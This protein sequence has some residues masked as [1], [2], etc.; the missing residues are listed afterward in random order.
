MRVPSTERL[1]SPGFAIWHMPLVCRTWTLSTVCPVPLQGSILPPSG[2]GSNPTW[3]LKLEPALREPQHLRPIQR[4]R[5]SNRSE[6]PPLPELNL[7]QRQAPARL[8][9]LLVRNRF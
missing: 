5:Q 7:L 8:L 1:A 4:T 9:P 3:F 6:P 2:R